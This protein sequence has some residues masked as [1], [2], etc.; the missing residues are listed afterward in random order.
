MR[1]THSS[2]GRS[3]VP[4]GTGGLATGLYWVATGKLPVEDLDDE[5]DDPKEAD[6]NMSKDPHDQKDKK[7]R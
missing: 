6:R 7:S 3:G 2:T 5:K 1:N 4:D